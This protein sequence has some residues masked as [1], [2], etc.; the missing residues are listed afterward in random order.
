MDIGAI[1]Q[2]IGSVGFPIVMSLLFFYYVKDTQESMTK[3]ISELKVSI[4]KL[5]DMITHMT[6]TGEIKHDS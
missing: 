3:A 6:E 1:G 5:Y 2:L 4:D